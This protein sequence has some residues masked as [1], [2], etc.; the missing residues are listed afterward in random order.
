MDDRILFE[1]DLLCGEE[2][3]E[4]RR[5]SKATGQ[6]LKTAAAFCE[7]FTDVNIRVTLLVGG[8]CTVGEGKVIGESM[9]ETFRSFY[10]LKE[11]N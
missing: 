6:A 1:L 8:A 4:G 10:D 7:I 3:Q 5:P 9:A 2:E 11:S